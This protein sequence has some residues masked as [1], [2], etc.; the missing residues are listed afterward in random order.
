MCLLAQARPPADRDYRKKTLILS[1]GQKKNGFRNPMYFLYQ[2]HF[3]F[4]TECKG[5]LTAPNTQDSAVTSCQ[6]CNKDK[7]QHTNFNK[8]IYGNDITIYHNGKTKKMQIAEVNISATRWRFIGLND[9]QHIESASCSVSLIDMFLL[10][11]TPSGH[12]WCC[13]YNESKMGRIISSYG[14]IILH[15]AT[16]W[17]MTT[18]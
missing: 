17:K 6:C 2:S 12:T 16:E 13:K 9:M 11:S 8:A 4:C 14:I 3:S 7:T 15:D 10:N 5:C 18:I 1:V